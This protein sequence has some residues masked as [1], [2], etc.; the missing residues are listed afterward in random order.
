M[1]DSVITTGDGRTV[2]IADY[3]APAGHPVLWCHGGPGSRLEPALHH[4][5]AAAAGIRIIGIDRPGYGLSTVQPGR[6]IAGWVPDALA[7]ADHLGLDTFHAVGVSTGGAYALA[8][9]AAAPNRVL[10]VV[11]CCAMTDMRYEPARATMGA[12]AHDPWNA[13]DRA[14]AIAAVTA[15][16]G[17]DG[18]K[19][20]DMDGPPLAPADMDLLADPEF[21]QQ[22]M[23]AMPANF[24]NGVQGYTD[25]RLADGPGWTTFDVGTITCPVTVLHGSADTIVDPVHAQ[26]T[27]SLLPNAQLRIVDDLGHLSI[28]AE[29]VPTLDE[30]LRH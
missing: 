25:D 15:L 18:S 9:A 21:L 14:A 17:D 30:M 24:A 5:P 19:M 12:A 7:V 3:G 23:T 10:G 20:L 2:G 27:A 4:Q 29:V 22:W 8:L 16:F 28:A 26:H 11:A 6:T 13:P 1:T